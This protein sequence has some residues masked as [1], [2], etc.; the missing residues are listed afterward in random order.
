MADP[1]VW[2]RFETKAELDTHMGHSGERV[3]PCPAPDVE[4]MSAGETRGWS[5]RSTRRARSNGVT[6]PVR[7]AEAAFEVGFTDKVRAF[8]ARPGVNR[9]RCRAMSLLWSSTVRQ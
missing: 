6:V 1:P 5:E 7:Q 8:P 9:V 4:G 3:A 2:A